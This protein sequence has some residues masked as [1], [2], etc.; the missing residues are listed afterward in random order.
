MKELT[1]GEK[2]KAYDEALERAKIWK[3]KSGMPKDKQGI[4]DDIFPELKESEDGGIKE[5]LILYLKGISFTTI[6][7]AEQVRNWIAWLEKQGEQKHTPK[8]K[9]GDTIYYNSFGEVKSMIVTN[10]VTDSTDNPMYEDENGSAVFEEDLIEKPALIIPKFRV[11]DE[12]KTTN[13]APLTITK[14]T[15]SG[16]WSEDL[17]ICSFENSAKWELVGK[18]VDKVEPKFQEGEWITNGDYTWQIVNVT[19]LD[20]ILQLQNGHIVDDT[21]SHVDEQFHSF[22]IEDA[23]DGDVLAV[24]PIKGYSFP[25]IAIYKE[26]GLDF[27]NSYCFI[28]FD[29]NFYDKYNIRHSIKNIYPATKEQCDLLFQKMKEAG[30]EWDTEKKELKKVVIPIFNIGDTIAKKHNSDINDFGSFTITDITGGK[31]WYND[32]IICDITE[33]DEWELVKQKPT[34][35]EPQIGD[36]FRKKDTISPTYHLCDKREDG[37]TFGFVENR[38]VGFS[39][40]EI[41]IF[42]LKQDYELV[43]RP[44]LIENVIE[45]E[46]NKTLQTKSEQKPAWNEEDEQYLLVCKNAL[47][48]YQASDKWDATIISR[49]LEDKLNSLKGRVQPQ[50]TWKPSEGQI[51]SITCAVRKMKESACYDSELVSLFNDLKKLREE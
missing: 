39:G 47:A 35:W 25:F 22:T 29:G 38:E 49:W 18:H 16:Y 9:V 5:E 23:K 24:E 37:I 13:E 36:T 31:Y 10:V 33:Q 6:E 41:T 51:A 28:G 17:F 7:R 19:D 30:Y 1:I 21:I 3:D 2:A 46:L 44:K 40:G 26:G 45:E 11:G 32:R 8:H 12:I 34:E 43:E 48:K 50:T 4:L 27:F 20:Y 15:D 14:I 42:T